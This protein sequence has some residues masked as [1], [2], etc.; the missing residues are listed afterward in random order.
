MQAEKVGL[1][2]ETGIAQDGEHKRRRVD[3]ELG[4]RERNE[5][6][7]AF[8]QRRG[9]PPPP[10]AES[11]PKAEDTQPCSVG[12]RARLRVREWIPVNAG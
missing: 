3:R 6:K 8:T 11:R 9:L 2:K 1:G 4:H 5:R 12:G 10:R 7:Q